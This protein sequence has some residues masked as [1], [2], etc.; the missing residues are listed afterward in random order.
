MTILSDG[1]TAIG[2]IAKPHIWLDGSLI[3]GSDVGEVHEKWTQRV[4]HSLDEVVTS[5]TVIGGVTAFDQTNI[6]TFDYNVRIVIQGN[7]D[8]KF[9]YN[10]KD[11][12]LPTASNVFEGSRNVTEDQGL[13]D[14][15]M[16]NNYAETWF[17]MNG[18]DPVRGKCYLYKYSDMG[19][20]IARE[21]SGKGFI[22]G[23]CQTGSDLITIKARTFYRGNKSRIA[24]ARFKI[25]RH[26]DLN[27]VVNGV[28]VE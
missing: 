21:L 13:D 27:E 16:V 11:A 4:D 22:L 8:P 12:V 10:T 28:P 14:Q 19:D 25:A 20:Q 26:T 23:S 7:V 24:I 3:V 2:P 6:L 1:S 9:P 18:K 5:S 15:L 17:T